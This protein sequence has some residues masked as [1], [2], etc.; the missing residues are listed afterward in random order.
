MI[1]RRDMV[2]WSAGLPLS[3]GLIGPALAQ[4][5]TIYS[6]PFKGA[7][8]AHQAAGTASVIENAQGARLLRFTAFTVTN[9]PDLRVYLAAGTETAQIT[10]PSTVK[11][12]VLKG[13]KGDQNYPV[14]AGTDLDRLNT[15]VIWCEPFSV[16]F[17]SAVL[18][19]G[20][21]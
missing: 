3:A 9:G 17:G 4:A 20:G 2:R 1:T 13:N 16:L 11:L 8:R 18:V 6:G 10:G 14:P 7:D 21:A 15:V 5:K 19:K 12:G